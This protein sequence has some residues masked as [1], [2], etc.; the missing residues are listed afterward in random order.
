MKNNRIKLVLFPLLL[1]TIFLI[2]IITPTVAGRNIKTV[3]PE[4]IIYED[5]ITTNGLILRDEIVL[6]NELEISEID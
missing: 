4:K 2:I 3:K 6:T 5:K 1:L